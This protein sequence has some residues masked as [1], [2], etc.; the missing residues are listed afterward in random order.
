ML[1]SF[2]AL[3]T[4]P[5][6]APISEVLSARYRVTW[7]RYLPRLRLLPYYRG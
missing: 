1:R 5:D 6:G 4:F 3:R 7:E 2:P